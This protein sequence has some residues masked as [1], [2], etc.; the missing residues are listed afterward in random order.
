MPPFNTTP[1]RRDHQPEDP[2][3][4]AVRA[5]GAALQQTKYAVIGG[6]ACML[7][8]STR[9]TRDV[10]FVVPPG[11]TRA[12][13]Q[14]LRNAEGFDIEPRTLHTYYRGVEIEILAPPAL[15]KEPYNAETGGDPAYQ[16]KPTAGE[17][18]N[19][20]KQF[21][22]WFTAT[23]YPSEEDKA[24]WEQVGFNPNTATFDTHLVVGPAKVKLLNQSSLHS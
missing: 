3:L 22:D 18:P 2:L 14:E 16:P 7:L 9:F 21:H 8:G 20:T 24:L 6:S 11:Q 15:F 10:D 13:R 1:N 4:A 12:A 19:A 23:Y 17:V 5:V